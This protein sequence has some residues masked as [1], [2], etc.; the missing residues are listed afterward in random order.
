MAATAN[1]I[2]ALQVYRE[3]G[4]SST[5]AAKLLNKSRS[6]VEELIAR[7]LKWEAAGESPGQIEALSVTGLDVEIGRH[8]WNVVVDPKTGSRHSVFWKAKDIR[9]DPVNVAEVLREALESVVPYAPTT[10]TKNL[11]KDL[12]NFIPLADLH[13]GGQYGDPSYLIEVHRVIEK[14]VQEIPEATKAVLI[15]MG[16]LLDANDHK[17]LTPA[18]GNECD[19]IRENHLKNTLD[20]LAIM[21]LAAVRLLA[22]HEE[23]EIHFLRG[24]HDETAYIAVM[25]ALEAYFRDEPRITIVV[26]D[27]DFRVIPWGKCAIFP[28][29]GDKSKWEDLMNVFSDQFPDA[30]AKAKFWRFVW[31]AHLH[32]DRQRELIGAMGE[33]FRTL[34]APNRWAKLKG[35][36]SRGGVQ[37][38]TL[39][40][41]HGEVGR[42]KVNLTPLLLQDKLTK[43]LPSGIV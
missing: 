31:T 22:T 34:A 15:E 9:L 23:V 7:A 14:L 24:N 3:N 29:H 40:K 21:K 17:G 41:E 42:K 2:E 27:D 8:G 33:H 36:F 39:H 5:K 20:A 18:S 13:I 16:D 26:S 19:V 43:S 38:I 25:I 28:H 32:N 4:N 10:F 1:Q 30:W 12:C 11:P 35:L 37:C 6:T